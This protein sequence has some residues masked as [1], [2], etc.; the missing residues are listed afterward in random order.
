M[1][2]IVAGPDARFHPVCHACGAPAQGVHSKVRRVL[3]DLHL[4]AAKVFI[5]CEYRKVYCSRCQ[6]VRVEDL[7]FFNP[8]QRVTKRLACYVHDLC[9]VL[10]V[11]EVA[12]HVDLDW[13]TVKNIDKAFLEEEFGTTDYDG[14]HTLAVDEIAIQKGHKYMTVVLDYVT[15]R[16]VWMGKDRKADTLRAFFKGMTQDQK[17]ALEAIAMDMWDPFIKAV[18][19]E[20]PHVKIVFDLFHVVHAFNKVIDKVRIA[21]KKKAE[22]TELEVYKGAK[23]LL[24]KNRRN[25]RTAEAHAHLQRL[26]DMNENISKVMILKDCLKRIWRYARRGWAQKRL[27]EWCALA[28]T[29]DN[30][31]VHKFAAML[32]RR[33]YG[34]LNHCDYP[35]HTSKLEGV[36]NKI[37]V[38]KRKAYGFHDQRYFSLKV[39]QAFH[40]H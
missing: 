4:G 33:T 12:E 37:K 3:R 22:K 5:N 40:S 32:E 27:D 6:G 9:K 28:R 25:I 1:A 15:G 34:I 10:T 17:D 2:W 29:I 13:K 23:Y 16:V 24:L 18:R 14:L 35:I 36:N 26:V 30:P 11:A 39:I 7:D 19:E 8:Y 31:D 21:E 38:I 20:A